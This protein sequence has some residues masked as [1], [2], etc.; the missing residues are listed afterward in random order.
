MT[1]LD[2]ILFFFLLTL[3]RRLACVVL[4]AVLRIITPRTNSKQSHSKMLQLPCL[5]LLF[6]TMYQAL[7]LL[8]HECRTQN[9]KHM[10]Q[11]I[12][13]IQNHGSAMTT[14]ATQ[15]GHFPYLPKFQDLVP[16]ESQLWQ[17]ASLRCLPR[18]A[19][20]IH[21]IGEFELGS[22]RSMVKEW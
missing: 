11:A 14:C 19:N 21:V 2:G 5:A 8:S 7:A 9:V 16:K 6:Q 18:E 3:Q 12:L 1:N 22:R 17:C 15:D 10:C 4:L 20:E 13:P